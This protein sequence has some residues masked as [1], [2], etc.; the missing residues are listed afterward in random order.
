L[1][2]WAWAFGERRNKVFARVSTFEGS[3]EQVEE[4]TRYASER[5]LPTLNELEGFNGILGLADRQSGRVLAVTLWETEE[6]MRTS[7]EA[8]NRLRDE[9]AEAASETKVGVE[10]YEVTFGEVKG[11]QL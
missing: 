2:T 8:A 6:A 1:V 9:S 4:L 10:R 11:T 5:V 3:P 7:E